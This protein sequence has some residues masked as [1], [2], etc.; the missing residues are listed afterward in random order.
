MNYTDAQKMLA[1]NE[2]LVEEI[3]N[4]KEISTIL[5]IPKPLDLTTV[6]VA[7]QRFVKDG[8]FAPTLQN[9]DLEP[10]VIFDLHNWFESPQL[11]FDW[12]LLK[13]LLKKI[14]Q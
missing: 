4:N 10:V 6:G 8:T 11:P 12:M 13:D 9:L 5:I 3:Y 7:V 1:E 2:H 14:N